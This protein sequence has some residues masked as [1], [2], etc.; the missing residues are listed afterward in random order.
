MH[1][2]IFILLDIQTWDFAKIDFKPSKDYVA[3]I[4]PVFGPEFRVAMRLTFPSFPP[5]DKVVFNIFRPGVVVM[6]LKIKS[7]GTLQLEF[8]SFT[9][10]FNVQA[11]KPYEIFLQHRG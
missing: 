2:I 11:Q 10:Q 7:D 8:E 3:T 5:E 6:I 4:F 9:H 1:N